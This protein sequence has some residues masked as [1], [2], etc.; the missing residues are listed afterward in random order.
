[1]IDLS[2]GDTRSGNP[3]EGGLPSATP[4]PGD[5]QRPSGMS[6]REGWAG[7]GHVA[8]ESGGL[9]G[10]DK[11]FATGAD[12]PAGNDAMDICREPLSRTY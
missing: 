10:R 12:S 2:E 8:L 6:A 7:E 3:G 11:G 4:T 9:R 1:V 5:A